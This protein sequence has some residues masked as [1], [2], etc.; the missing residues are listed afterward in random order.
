MGSNYAY[1][2]A[3]LPGLRLGEAPSMR[4][5]EFLEMC[6]GFVA[7]GDFHA[8]HGMDLLP[9][10]E[11]ACE[12]HRRWSV[13]ETDLRNWVARIRGARKKADVDRMLRPEGDLGAD[14]ERLVTEAM[15]LATPEET[16]RRLDEIRWR[17]LDNL[18]V[19]HEF[20]VQRVVVYR[21]QLLLAEKWT[22]LDSEAGLRAM[23]A[24]AGAM[25]ARLESAD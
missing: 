6:E 21:L 11:P 19:G 18:T 25:K 3:A 15:D 24:L 22:D 10:A 1:L 13:F 7:P 17:F 23:E 12:A 20:D 8:L 9:A 5:A 2:V 4:T 16:E 14:T